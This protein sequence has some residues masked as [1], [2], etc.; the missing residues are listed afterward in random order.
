M[1]RV[2]IIVASL[3][4]GLSAV[5]CDNF[6]SELP[7]NRTQL[8][9]KDK[10]ADLLVSAYP[11]YGYA[12][13]TEI[14][15]D[16]VDDNGK[17]SMTRDYNLSE[18]KWELEERNSQDSPS[19][20]W[21]G[22]YEAIAS[23][24]D[25][26]EAIEKLGG[27]PEL[28]HLKGEALVAR[29][30]AHFMLVQIWSKAYNPATADS[31]VG[32]PYVDKPER[33]LIQHYDRG[34]VADVYAKIEKDLEEGLPLLKDSYKQPKF[35][36]NRTAGHAFASNFYLV[37]GDWEKVLEHSNYLGSNPKMQ[38]RDY[39]AFSK[40]GYLEKYQAYARPTVNSNLLLVTAVSNH[41]R[42]NIWSRFW[43]TEDLNREIFG[44]NAFGKNWLYSSISYTAS[45]TYVY[46]K[47]GEY[48][49]LDDPSA[50]T[51]LPHVTYVLLSND[52][53]YLNRAEALAMSGR[54]DEA[55]DAL[56]LF[57]GTR[58]IG[59]KASDDAKFTLAKLRSIYGNDAMKLSPY[60]D[61]NEDQAVVVAAVL[62][63]K[64]REFMHEGKRWF[65][66]KRHNIEVVHKLK[67][68]ADMILT[69]DD[70]RRQLPL[71]LHVVSAG[72][73]DNPR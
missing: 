21:D 3:L 71:P 30:Y 15:S 12:G 2:K 56:R 67:D 61:M 24:N 34:T 14:M 66:V 43:L 31:D 55:V 44:Q 72:I 41:W 33:V 8:D 17:K 47:L 46:P 58:T 52:E 16:N 28:S 9:S 23:A 39:L 42:N 54:I 22:C 29:A 60:Y 59:Y 57:T 63:A 5:S 19:A 18:Y 11:I 35:H 32:I 62:S 20:Y 26:L 7:D 50:G 69:K 6:L 1:K 27:G 51:G 53:N 65:D 73:P 25:A 70:L 49:R 48:F 13:F 38:L 36:F 64:Q 37:K 4:I 68:E 10:I 40:L 45:G